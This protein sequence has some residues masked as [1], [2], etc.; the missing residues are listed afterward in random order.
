MVL[1][2]LRR[3]PEK[4]LY[5]LSCVELRSREGAIGEPFGLYRPSERSIHLYSLPVVWRMSEFAENSQASVEGYFA[6]VERHEDHVW[7]RWP[8]DPLLSLWFFFEVFAHELG[9]H[10]RNQYRSKRSAFG[11]T[12]DEEIVADLHANRLK[13][14]VI[15]Q[16]R[17]RNRAEGRKSQDA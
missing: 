14:R 1:R 11:R 15:T 12:V 10:F 16:W 17:N 9:H 13:V 8:S 3:T 7:I 2:I 4:Y 5:G 6:D